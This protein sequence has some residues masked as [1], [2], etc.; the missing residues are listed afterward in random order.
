MHITASSNTPSYCAGTLIWYKVAPDDRFAQEAAVLQCTTCG[1]IFTSGYP[2]DLAHAR[3][4][5]LF[6]GL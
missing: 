3:A 4:G 2:V 1:A 6:E 5:V